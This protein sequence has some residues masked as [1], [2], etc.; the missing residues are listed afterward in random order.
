MDARDA[1]WDSSRVRALINA[2]DVGGLLRAARQARGWRQADLGHASGYSASTISRLETRR[3]APSDLPT[4]RR[5][6]DAVA[7]PADVLGAALGLSSTS[8]TTVAAAALQ[9]RFRED[10][11][12]RRTF[13]AAAGLAVPAPAL[14]SLE[15]A[16]APRPVPATPVTAGEVTAHLA[17]ARALFDAGDLVL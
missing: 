11:V 9:P 7:I 13:L 15:E 8:S 3:R 17:R 14:A 1:L 5:V 16:L 2:R 4:L 12:K 10:P 6:A